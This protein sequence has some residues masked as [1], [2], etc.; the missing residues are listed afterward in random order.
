[1]TKRIVLCADDYGQAPEISQGILALLKYGRLSAVSCMVNSP[2]W[3]EHAKWLTPFR[4]KADIGLHFNLTEGKATSPIFIAKYG[5]TLPS[6]R[7]LLSK[8]LLR[9]WDIPT[10]EAEFEAQIDCFKQALG[11]NPDFIDGHQHI[12]QFPNVREAFINVYKRRFSEA[13]KPYVRSVNP[14]IHLTDIF[15]NSKKLI[16][17]LTGSS[18]FYKILNN[19]DISCNTSYAGIYAFSQAGKYRSLF[20]SFLTSCKSGGLIMCH[21]GLKAADSADSI[22]DAR[23][24]EYQYLF[25]DQ[26]LY[27][28]HQQDVVISRFY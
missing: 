22:A 1:M 2:H 8:A 13:H 4:P 6:L 24:L 19:N 23:Y 26:F 21:P 7:T 11:V 9:Q 20:I 25:G 5:E 3:V 15:N 17:Y 12:Q 14:R 16:I 28:C 27:D 10:F 18:I